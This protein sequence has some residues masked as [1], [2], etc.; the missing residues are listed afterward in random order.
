MLIAIEEE[1]EEK[2]AAQEKAY[3]LVVQK[4]KKLKQS[5]ILLT[6]LAMFSIYIMSFPVIILDVFL[7]QYQ[8]IYFRIMGI[9]TINRSDYIVMD[10]YNLSKLNW[11]QKLNCLYCEYVNGFL[12]YARDVANQTEIYSC[13]IKH[14]TPK[15]GQE[16]QENFYNYSDFE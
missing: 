3:G 1:Q 9:P 4:D 6:P 13:A 14:N 7:W 16:H 5:S 10:R 2:E 11:L 8:N 15:K 12:T